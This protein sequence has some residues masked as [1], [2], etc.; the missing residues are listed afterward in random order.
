MSNKLFAKLVQ[1]W[2]DEQLISQ[3]RH[4]RALIKQGKMDVMRIG[5]GSTGEELFSALMTL[6]K[7]EIYIK[8][9]EQE[10]KRRH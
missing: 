7:A 2:T 5:W 3:G 6:E 10:W 8:I 9:L 1:T 4:V